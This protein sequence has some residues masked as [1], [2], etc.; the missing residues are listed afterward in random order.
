M[1]GVFVATHAYSLYD[2]A[3]IYFRFVENTAQG[4]V[5]RWNC[6]DAP[7][8]GF[9]SPLYFLLL[10]AT[11]V[12][13]PDL[14][15]ASQLLGAVLVAGA[16]SGAIWVVRRGGEPSSWVP[17]AL[18]L[19]L[20]LDGYVLLNATIGLET[21]LAC[22]AVVAVFC[23]ALQD[24]WLAPTVVLAVL[25]RPELGVLALALPV[26]VGRD[27]IVRLGGSVAVGLLAIVGARWLVFHDWLPNTFW[28]KTGGTSAHFRLGLAYV[29]EALGD[30]PLVLAAPLAARIDGWK[31]PVRYVLAATG[32]QLAFFLYS[33][34]DT[35][36]Y[37]RLFMPF[38]PL[39][40]AL[41]IAGLWHRFAT[42]RTLVGAGIAIVLAAGAVRH[43][44][45]PQHGFANVKRWAVVGQWL[46]K[47]RPPTTK[48]AVVPIGAIGY[49]SRL[50]TLDLVGLATREVA[51]GDRVPAERL[52]RSW[53]G[54]EKHNT[55]FIL[56]Q[57]PD[58]LV[59]TKWRGEPWTLE[60]ARAGFWAEKQ[61]LDAIRGSGDYRVVDAQIEAG[62]H[63]LM[64]ER[65]AR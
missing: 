43:Y 54:H 28:A 2:D 34:G 12:V 59:F 10:L 36:L 27:R 22:G 39:L 44:L 13:T 11:R 32:I 31:R 6:G 8:E 62:V 60:E 50:P 51:R 46:R 55:R 48:I 20:G 7:V 29:V 65:I 56:E 30:F 21:G 40:T 49:F 45:P 58:L 47:T 17:G 52:V 25:V 53:I 9:T 64:F 16:L 42:R 18:L 3:Y 19:L 61:L 41:A 38:V 14:E 35:F 24:R 37:S 26:V 5:L 23:A 63:W 1:V 33:G 4:C 15:A 57:R